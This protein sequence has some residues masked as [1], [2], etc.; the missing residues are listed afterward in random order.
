MVY[1]VYSVNLYQPLLE[2]R[3]MRLECVKLMCTCEA[4]KQS[5]CVIHL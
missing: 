3:F 4:L 5:L 1:N 2:N